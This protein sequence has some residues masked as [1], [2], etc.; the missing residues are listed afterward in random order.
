MLLSSPTLKLP[1]EGPPEFYYII[2]NVV[3]GIDSLHLR[4]VTDQYGS[5]YFDKLQLIQHAIIIENNV[6]ELEI[7]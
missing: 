4:L 1:C 5:I 7:S 2:K 3:V 6:V